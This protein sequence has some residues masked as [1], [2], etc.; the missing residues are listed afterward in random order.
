MDESVYQACSDVA[1]RFQAELGRDYLGIVACGSQIDGSAKLGSDLDVIVVHKK[2]WRQRRV[3]IAGRYLVDA[4]ILPVSQIRLAFKA[5]RTP[6][7][8]ECCA[9][10]KPI[11]SRSDVVLQLVSEARAKYQAGPPALNETETE[12]TRS[13]LTIIGRSVIRALESGDP[14]A[15]LRIVPLV[16]ALIY[17]RL[18]VSQRWRPPDRKLLSELGKCD[19]EAA[20]IVMQLLRESTSAL[21]IPFLIR[22]LDRVLGPIQ[23]I[24]GEWQTVKEP[25]K[26]SLLLRLFGR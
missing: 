17:H 10:G 13:R 16:L 21:K 8:L 23:N 14:S 20:M 3:F 7:I 5:F 25:I 26:R 12:I 4:H 15:E 19:P 18:A 6:G 9:K 2:P 24:T 1:R 22:L 11:E